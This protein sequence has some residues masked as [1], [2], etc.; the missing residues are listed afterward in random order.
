MKL[1]IVS[2]TPFEIAPLKEWLAESFESTTP[3]LYTKGKLSIQLLITGVG[4]MHTTYALTKYLATSKP[5]LAINAGIAGA[6]KRQ[7]KLG[8]V[9][10]VITE[11]LS[12]VGIE[13]AN[14]HFTG[15]HE[16]GLIDPDQAPFQKGLL[17]NP[18]QEHASFL[19]CVH[20][21]SVNTVHGFNANI[22]KIKQQ[23]PDVEIESMEGAAFFY[24]CLM[25]KVPFLQI[26]AISNYVES[27]NRENW[28]IELAIDQLGNVLKGMVGALGG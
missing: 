3:D 16:L 27:R 10:N 5:D 18:Q 8:E 20:G 14:G 13:E 28:R 17:L 2:A 1:L 19:P 9:V 6:F 26:R 21:L 22:L 25:E 4:M 12:D 11:R 15:I 23:H 24:T 7:L